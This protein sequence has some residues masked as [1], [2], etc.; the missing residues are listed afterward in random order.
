[1]RPVGLLLT[2]LN[3]L[4]RAPIPHQAKTRLIPA[5]GPEGAARAQ[6]RLLRHVVRIGQNWCQATPNRLFRLWCSP[7]TSHPFFATLTSPNNL[8]QQPEGDLAVRLQQVLYHEQGETFNRIL[9]LGGDT[10]SVT[11]QLL[12]QAET[13]LAQHP[14][15]LAPSEDGGYALLGVTKPTPHL[16]HD[17]P[18]GGDKVAE[19]TRQRLRELGWCW[20]ELAKQWDVDTPKDWQRFTQA[21][22]SL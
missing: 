3:I 18:W 17:I 13:A 11:S 9:L 22:P 20:Q 12:D 19:T 6:M 15:V 14:A 8:R 7:D 5:L 10:A 4:G 21:F 2:S 1:M 16:F